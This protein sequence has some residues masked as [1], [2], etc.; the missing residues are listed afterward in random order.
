MKIII[1]PQKTLRRLLII[2]TV[3][4]TANIL[5]VLMRIYMQPGKKNILVWLFDFDTEHNIPT[6]YSSLALVFCAVLL[7]VIGLA[8]RNAGNPY[9]PW[10]GL[11]LIFLFLSIDE[12]STLHENLVLPAR[13][14]F[15]AT[16]LLHFAWMI[17]YGIALFILGIIYFKFLIQLPQPAKAQFFASGAVFLA[18]AIGFEA[19]SGL[20]YSTIGVDNIHPLKV[21]ALYTGEDLLEMMGVAMFIYSLLHYIKKHFGGL[22]LSTTQT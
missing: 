10:F 1:D 12:T 7:Y 19:V 9:R 21:A 16:G 20:L 8:H 11:A 2:I 14:F 18:G 4:L 17:P 13:N 5:G 15:H 6:L 3:L 22:L